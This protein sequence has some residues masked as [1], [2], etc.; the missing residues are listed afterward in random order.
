MTGDTDFHSRVVSLVSD[1]PV[2]KRN[3]DIIC[4]DNHENHPGNLR[5]KE[6]IERYAQREKW[7]A[8]LEDRV[9]REIQKEIENQDDSP[10]FLSHNSNGEWRK[11]NLD[12]IQNEIRGEW[13]SAIYR[14]FEGYNRGEGMTAV[15]SNIPLGVIEEEINTGGETKGTGAGAGGEIGEKDPARDTSRGKYAV[16]IVV[17]G[18]VLI[19]AIVLGIILPR[20]NDKEDE[21]GKITSPTSAPTAKVAMDAESE[22]LNTILNRGK[23]I[24]G[25]M[26]QL[27]F[28][29]QDAQGI[30]EGFEVDLC[31]AVAAGIFGMDKFGDR[32]SEPVEF[33][34]LEAEE[35]FPSL[36]DKTID[37]LLAMT[38]QTIE[39]SLYEVCPG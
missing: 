38:S 10:F 16:V 19:L 2:P 4:D 3:C 37:L 1:P 36:N 25:V 5:M 18:I 29:R 21:K 39:R 30:W 14:H 32:P 15:G 31:R 6:I 12:V 33:I 23:L 9:L 34:P 13:G 17:V 22:T 35:R 27:G 26:S 28:A 8:T 7:N 20:K 11:A 24:C